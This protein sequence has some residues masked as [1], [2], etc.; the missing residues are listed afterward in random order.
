MITLNCCSYIYCS[1]A[2]AVDNPELFNRIAGTFH[3][4]ATLRFVILLWGEKS[5]LN[6][7]GIEELPVFSYQEIIDLG[8][9]SYRAFFGAPDSSK[10]H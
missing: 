1:I 9:E 2:L 5:S 8:Q 3:S 7:S 10:Y 4:K 6:F